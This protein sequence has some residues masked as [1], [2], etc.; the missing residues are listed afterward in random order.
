MIKGWRIAILVS[1]LFAAIATPA[2]DIFSMLMLGGILIV[3]YFAAALLSVFFDRRKRK[4]RIAAGLD[5]DGIA[6]A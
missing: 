1:A 4:Q 3:L 2:A 5:P 6:T